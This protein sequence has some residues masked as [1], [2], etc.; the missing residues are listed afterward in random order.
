MK[1]LILVFIAFGFLSVAE[2]QTITIDK[3][4]PEREEWFQSL[5]FGMFIHWSVDVQIGAIISHNV[6]ASSREYQDR[7]FNELPRYFDPKSF[8]PEEWAKLA[9]LAGMKYMVFTAKHHNGF[10]MWDTE[11]VDFKI[12]NTPYGKDIMKEIIDAFRKYDIPIGLYFSPD[13][14]YLNYLEEIPPSRIL[15]EGNPD[16]NK[17]MWEIEKKQIRELLTNYGKIDI[18]FIDEYLDYANTLVADYCWEIDP[19]LVITRGGMET[20][21]QEI[22]DK[23]IPGPWE[24]CFTIGRHWAHVPGDKV[25]DGLQIINMLIETRAKGGNLLLNVSPDSHGKIP[26]EQEARLREVALWMMSNQD[27]VYEIEPFTVINE[28]LS[29]NWWYEEPEHYIWFTRSKTGN[30]VYAFVPSKNW[31]I[32]GYKTFFIRSLKGNDKTRVSVL[33]QHETVMEY[34]LK[35]PPKPIISVVKEGIFINVIRTHRT[36]KEWHNPVVIKIEN[37]AYNEL[38][39]ELD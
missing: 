14:F 18:F 19:N 39:E 34:K 9:K 28:K 6:A 22:P 31:G 5:G 33:G 10:C 37:V 12:T 7:Y 29:S 23:P 35:T 25:K 11:T 13:D 20:P 21:E 17:E 26:Q 15:P 38:I 4:K 24:A 8:D 30:T 32:S 1:K 36:N 27:A 16:N 2:A 3:N